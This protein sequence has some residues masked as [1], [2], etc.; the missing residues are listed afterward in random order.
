M[1]SDGGGRWTEWLV[2]IAGALGFNKVR[3]R[4]KLQRIGTRWRRFVRRSEQ[5]ANHVRYAHKT[6][7]ACGSVQDRDA[8][9]CSR[10]GERLGRRG[11]QVLERIGVHAPALLSTSTW[12]AGL[13]ALA[14]VGL[15]VD[16]GG[17]LASVDWMV[18]FRHGGQYPPAV[19]A[20]EYWRLLTALFLHAGIWH[21]GFNLVA[22]AIV[23]PHVEELYGDAAIATV[24]V[25]GG[26][27]A[28]AASWQIGGAMSVG[29]SGAVMAL[30][31]LAAAAGHR[32]GTSAGRRIRNDMLKWLL[33]TTLFG[34][35][36]GADHAAHFGGFA[37]GGALG[38][39]VRPA[40]V[41]TRRG[42][43][44]SRALG[45]ACAA[46]AAVGAYWTWRPPASRYL[47]AIE[48]DAAAEVARVVGDLRSRCDGGASGSGEPRDGAAGAPDAPGGGRDP[49]CDELDALRRKCRY[50]VGDFLPPDSPPE[51]HAFYEGVCDVLRDGRDRGD[52]R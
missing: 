17:G 6:C 14:Y 3:V 39:A 36:M 20:G 49:A 42:R 31:G 26:L 5:R 37:A 11:W 35:M 44:V 24:F 13:C 47:A 27:A 33:Y 28:S 23:A 43:A 41:R 48:R 12:I 46:V 32:E 34:L 40:A 16:G 30:I 25:A 19:D 9:A 2:A 45:V 15:V 8:E 52:G 7:T 18:L 10:C 1:A 21:I 4:W 38:L 29:A 22:L 50:D 51:L